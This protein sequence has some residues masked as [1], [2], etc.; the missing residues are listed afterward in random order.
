V[1]PWRRAAHLPAAAY[2]SPAMHAARLRD[3]P[4]RP[5]RGSLERP[6]NARLVRTASLVCLLPLLIVVLTI[7]RPGPLPAPGLPA[8]FDGKAA[9]SLTRALVTESSNRTPGST[10]AAQAAE[11]FIGT[12]AQYGLA[13]E[14]DVWT[15]RVPGLGRVQLRNLAVVVPGS[16]RGAIVVV[17]HRDN[18][19]AGPGANDNASGTAALI[20]L[21]RAYAT[22][23]TT[24]VRPRPLHTLVFLSTDAGA[25]GSVG[26][27]RFVSTSRFR[28]QLIAAVVLEGLASGNRPRIDFAGDSGRSPTPALTRT[29]SASVLEQTGER[30]RTA[31]LMRQLVD[32]AVPFAYGEQAPFL[33]KHVAAVRLTT[34]DDSGR[35]EL[36][37]RADLLNAI[38]F[39]RLGAAAQNLIGSLDAGGDLV[40]G[41]TPVVDVRGRVIRGWAVGLLVISL[42]VPYGI[43][44]LDLL[45]R[46][47]RHGIPLAPAF[48]A[49][50]RRLGFWL[51]TGALLWLGATVGY[52][53]EGP[54]RPLPP[55]G[56][57]AL[58]WPLDATLVLGGLALGG[59]FLARRR[60]VPSRQPTSEEELAG[61][62]ASLT[63]L[64]ILAL[65][66]AFYHPLAL[67]LL[68]P[69]LYAWLWLATTSDRAWAR[70]VFYGAGLAGAAL[71][72]VSIGGRFDLGARTPLY[73]VELV[74]VGYI[75]WFTALLAL[76]WLAV[77]AQLGALASG[78]YGAYADG[79]RHPPP[80]VIRAAVRRLALASRARRH[81]RRK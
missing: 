60:L 33:G 12:L 37:D 6:I 42:L 61:Y 65:A 18:S 4:R 67:L 35:S 54:A 56:G 5:R 45:A 11:W 59:W 3:L 34:A 13:T 48:R 9:V 41:T 78:R 32:L 44:L 40:Q 46:C 43:A 30:P 36:D 75:P 81:S 31:G 57:A 26:A 22:V 10:G 1:R 80:G 69:S 14:S 25:Y 71:V 2:Y 47:R 24:A 8:S 53:P 68:L 63:G 51:W 17:A 27:S 55:H 16:T 64:G 38:V 23:G 62:A 49:L 39:G 72:L 66:V 52:L 74:T 15:Q 20:Q 21:A 73:L 79:A 77:A 58:S 70:D 50:R 19:G 76:I 28:K 7:S 29:V